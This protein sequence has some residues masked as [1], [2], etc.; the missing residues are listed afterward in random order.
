MSVR[1]FQERK[2]IERILFSLPI[3]A[4]C[5]ALVVLAAWGVVRIGYRKYIIDREVAALR[6]E[7]AALEAQRAEYEERFRDLATPEGLDREA[8]GKF[9]LKKEGEEVVLFLENPSPSLPDQERGVA[10]VW[11]ALRDWIEQ[12]FK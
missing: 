3:L 9:N 2:K 8:R 6:D 7:I 1:D 11:H 4:L 12:W 5:T 10:G